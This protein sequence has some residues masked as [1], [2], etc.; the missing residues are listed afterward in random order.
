ML[1]VGVN[2]VRLGRTD[3]TLDSYVLRMHNILFMLP[4]A[5]GHVVAIETYIFG[6]TSPALHVYVLYLTYSNYWSPSALADSD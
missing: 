1:V 2:I 4:W 5:A 6:E 3:C